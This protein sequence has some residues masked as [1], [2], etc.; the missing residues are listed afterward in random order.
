MRRAS[1]NNFGFGGSNAH[2]ILDD[3]YKFMECHSVSA[4]RIS[5]NGS[6]ND[7]GGLEKK[8]K[9]TRLFPLSALDAEAGKRLLKTLSGYLDTHAKTDSE[10]FLADL[11]YTIGQRRSLL[12]LR[13]AVSASSREELLDKFSSGEVTFSKIQKSSNIGFVFTGQGAQWAGM[14]KELLT[15]YPTF[16]ESMRKSDEYL[17]KLGADWSLIGTVSFSMSFLTSS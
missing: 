14:G 7:I 3:S 1:V 11:A 9:R 16:S 8:V 2:V 13:A 17:V 4:S 5:A 15:S 10:T 6:Q 12:P